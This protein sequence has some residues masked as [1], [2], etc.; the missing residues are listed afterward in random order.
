MIGYMLDT[1]GIR[2][3]MEKSRSKLEVKKGHRGDHR[4]KDAREATLM[5]FF[6]HS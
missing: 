3:K 5:P 4:G 2:S 6:S 1:M